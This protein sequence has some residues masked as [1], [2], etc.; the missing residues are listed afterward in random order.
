MWI[1]PSRVARGDLRRDLRTAAR[2]NCGARSSA[3]CATP[4]TMCGRKPKG[5]KRR[6][7]LAG[8]PNVRE[9]PRAVEGHLSRLTAVLGI[10]PLRRLMLGANGTSAIGTLV[11]RVTRSFVLVRMPTRKADIAACAFAAALNAI[12]EPPGQDADLRPGQGDGRP[13]GPREGDRDGDLLRRPVLL[14]AGR[15]APMRIQS[16]Y[17]GSTSRRGSPC[18]ALTRPIST[19]SRTP[20]TTGR[21]RRWS[22]QRRGGSSSGNC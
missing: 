17:C 11:E 6:G 8:M 15:A 12:P 13:H 5:S 21:A 3:A 20:S 16:S 10:S 2:A 1:R 4:R 9:R 22:S 19:R 7:K 14:L 18:W